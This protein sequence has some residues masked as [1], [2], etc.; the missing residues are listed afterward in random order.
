MTAISRILVATD[1]STASFEALTYAKKL[2]EGFNASLHVIHAFDDPFTMAA[3]A[4]EVYAAPPASVRE[5]MVRDIERQLAEQVSRAD[6][7]RVAGK[8]E[9]VTGSP[10]SAIVECAQTLGSDLIVMGT[11][12]RGG[13]AHLLLGSVAERV[14]RTAVCPVLTVRA[15]AARPIRR[16]LVPTDFSAT[17]DAALDYAQLLAARFGAT[18]QLL[19]VLDDPFIDEGLVAEAYVSAGPVLRTALLRDAQARL[20]QRVAPL[21]RADQREGSPGLIRVEAEVLFGDGAHTIAEY[22]R[23]RQVDLV[24]MGTHGRRGV[25]HL[26]MGSVAERLV[27]T[28][29]CPVLTVRHVPAKPEHVELVY[30]VEHLPA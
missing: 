28:A 24:V 25:A 19:H 4:P 6:L 9:I 23:D 27:R 8:T 3:F 30:D 21:R 29:P 18:L 14:M 12:G 11:H 17:A 2:A 15:H 10:A 16:I 26:L 20:A 1:F 5:Q 22:A 13:M 7:G